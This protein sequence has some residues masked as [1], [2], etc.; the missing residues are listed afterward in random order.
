MKPRVAYC[1][2]SERLTARWRSCRS[3]GVVPASLVEGRRIGPGRVVEDLTFV[4]IPLPADNSGVVPDLGVWDRNVGNWPVTCAGLDRLSARRCQM[5]VSPRGLAWSRLPEFFEAGDLV[6]CHRGAGLAELTLPFPESLDELARVGCPGG[7]GVTDDCPP[8]LP[9]DDPAES[10]YQVRLAL[11]VLPGL[12]ARPQPV[13]G[14]TL[15]LCLAAVLETVLPCLA[16]SVL[17]ME[18]RAFHRR[19]VSRQTSHPTGELDGTAEAGDQDNGT[20]RADGP[21]VDG[22][23]L[24]CR[25]T[26]ESWRGPARPRQ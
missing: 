21:R 12:E 23:S 19:R 20:E 15:A 9:Q 11:A 1:T 22:T 10:C 26:V 3:Q 5:P 6:D 16:L 2:S 7:R 8:V 13:P 24:A 14:P 18:V 25:M 17:S 4:V